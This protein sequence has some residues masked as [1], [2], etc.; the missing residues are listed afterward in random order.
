MLH[1]S[2]PRMLHLPRTAWSSRPM[3]VAP[4]MHFAMCDATLFSARD[5]LV[6]QAAQ[7]VARSLASG[8]R[9]FSVSP[10]PE[11]FAPLICKP[12]ARHRSIPSLI[13]SARRVFRCRLQGRRPTTSSTMNTMMFGCAAL[14]SPAPPSNHTRNQ[15]VM[16]EALGSREWRSNLNRLQLDVSRLKK[17]P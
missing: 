14:N 5:A 15:R 10:L 7:R 13:A 16:G 12:H 3:R 6:A 8:A 4:P 11:K 2:S 1:L 9:R 17:T